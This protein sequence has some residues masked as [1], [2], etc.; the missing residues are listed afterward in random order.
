MGTGKA[1]PSAPPPERWTVK[2]LDPVTDHKLVEQI[3]F[4]A[5]KGRERFELGDIV[6]IVE[7]AS[8]GRALVKNAEVIRAYLERCM[9]PANPLLLDRLSFQDAKRVEDALFAFFGAA[10]SAPSWNG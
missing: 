9:E 4:R 6:T 7:T 1:A 3:E 5:P 8:G 2:L 10:N